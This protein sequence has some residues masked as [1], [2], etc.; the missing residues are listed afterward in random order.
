MFS[1]ARIS[2]NG[3]SVVAPELAVPGKTTAVFV[4]FNNPSVPRQPLNVTLRLLLGSSQGNYDNSNPPLVEVTEE[5]TVHLQIKRTTPFASAPP[6]RPVV[7][8]HFA[9]YTAIVT[10]PRRVQNA[11]SRRTP[12]YPEPIQIYADASRPITAKLLTHG[13]IIQIRDNK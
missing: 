13:I 3:F 7:A 11:R 5:I 12:A 1:F 9:R 8:A 10:N 4:T 6:R 2:T